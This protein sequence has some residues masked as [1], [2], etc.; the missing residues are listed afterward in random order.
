LRSSWSIAKTI[1]KGVLAIE[2]PDGFVEDLLARHEDTDVQTGF[3]SLVDPLPA[4][5]DGDGFVGNEEPTIDFLSN[6]D[7]E[8][9]QA[10]LL[11]SFRFVCA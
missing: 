3:L 8:I 11:G 7:R 6:F 9:Q 5:V 1:E 2:D 10:A 4:V